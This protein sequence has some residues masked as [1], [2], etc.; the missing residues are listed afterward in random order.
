MS[1][2]EEN[3]RPT[4]VD[5]PLIQIG[6]PASAAGGCGDGCGC[7]GEDGYDLDALE[8][9]LDPALAQL[10]ADA[11]LD[12]VTVEDVAHVAIEEDLDGGVDV[13]TVATVPEDAV[14]TG[15][16]TAR[17]AGV[18]A[19][20]RVAEAVLSIVCTDEFEVERHVEDGDRVAPG[21]KLLTVTTRTRD[22]LTGERS[23]LNL[24]CRLSGIATATRAW[25]DVL[26]G[27]KAEVRDTRKTTPGLR[28]LEKYAVRC[29]GGVNHR[30]SLSDAALVKD[31]HVI[32]A[33]GVAEAFKRVREE[34]PDLAIEVEVDT[35]EQ[36]TEVLD[37]GA[38]LILLD[39]FTPSQTAEAV[40]LVGGRA[41]LESSGRLSLESARAYAE[42]GVD[43]LAVG[44]LT[45]S[46]PILD[47]GL[48]F[49]DTDG[50]GV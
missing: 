32:A 39:N 6:A 16:F 11:G 20:L 44:A 9:G 14:A 12:P 13:T 46:S 25:A 49:R 15:D 5:V 28:A 4:P 22:L 48:D 35:M 17:E 33:G 43:Y 34:F 10:L 36:V 8:C 38:D 50:A 37:A 40:E 23:A 31:N 26:E 41:I 42:A 2:P 21:Q 18:V 7:G 1:T 29:G 45:H 3:P 47:I 19:G 24:L 30:M 27:T